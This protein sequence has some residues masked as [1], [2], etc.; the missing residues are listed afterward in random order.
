MVNYTKKALKNTVFVFLASSFAG[1]LAYFFKLLLARKLSVED[2]G[3]FYA[4]FAVFGLVAF[5]RQMGLSQTLVKHIAEFRI[6]RKFKE[7]KSYINTVFLIQFIASIIIASFFI[8]FSRQ[9]AVNYLKYPGAANLIM[10]FSIYFV[11][12]PVQRIFSAICQGFQ[13][14]NYYSL[15][16]VLEMIFIFVV[17]VLLFLFGFGVLAPIIAYASVNILVFLVI[18]PL[19]K[20]KFPLLFKLKAVYKLVTTKKIFKF[21]LPIFFT[22]VA[23][24]L[25]G[26]TDTVVI[27]FFR[28]MNEVA[29]YNVGMPTSRV[30]LVFSTSLA[31]ILLPL[32]SELWHKRDLVR[33]RDGLLQLYKYSTILILPLALLMFVFPEIILRILFGESYIGAA[34]VLRIL[35]FVGII[36]SIGKINNTIIVGIGKPS[37][38]TKYS[39]FAV[40]FNVIAD[41]IL[42]PIYGIVGA[43]AASLTA[44]V[45]LTSFSIF[46]IRR[47][48][49]VKIPVGVFAKI[50]VSAAVF[51]LVISVLKKVLV[52]NVW[53]ELTIS[54]ICGLILYNALLLIL[55]TVT[56]A[57]LKGIVKRIR[58]RF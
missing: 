42:V 7:I 12:L 35:S 47:L 39:I 53:A 45:I 57:E 16:T 31:V 24:A 22:G 40:L 17:T 43:A 48:I 3:L 20:K 8:I 21:A 52:M 4:V 5:L 54:I 58:A 9:I 23:S 50:I 28:S 55:K 51:L 38:V 41:I 11:L 2:F 18:Y 10:V 56:F 1:V 19:M 15:I 29:F 32:T 36:F 46:Y 30:L 49:K 26:Y 37:I 25:F 6:K 27:T 34:M 44:Y 14:M 13:K 33:L